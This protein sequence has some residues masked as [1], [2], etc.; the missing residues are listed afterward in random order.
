MAVSSVTA[1][2]AVSVAG[3]YTGPAEH[4]L[5]VEVMGWIGVT[6]N[7]SGAQIPYQV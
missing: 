2:V 3:G 6:S 4:T 7:S 5:N 1:F